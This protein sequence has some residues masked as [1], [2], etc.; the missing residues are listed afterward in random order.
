MTVR[1][2]SYRPYSD[3]NNTIMLILNN[4]RYIELSFSIFDFWEF[5][6]N[7]KFKKKTLL[8]MKEKNRMILFTERVFPKVNAISEMAFTCLKFQ[9]IQ[10]FSSVK[11]LNT[12]FD[13]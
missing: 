9:R 1:T 12:L 2:M 8:L 13:K 3:K 7:Q 6:S 10:N 5:F 11:H 4:L